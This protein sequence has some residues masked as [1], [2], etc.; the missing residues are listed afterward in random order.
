MAHQ[1]IPA[2]SRNDKDKT[3]FK[4]TKSSLTKGKYRGVILGP[5]GFCEQIAE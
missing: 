5:N 3:V 4:K 1:E 2:Q